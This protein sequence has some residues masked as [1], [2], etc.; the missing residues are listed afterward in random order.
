MLVGTADGSEGLKVSGT[1]FGAFVLTREFVGR[2]DG[3][4][5]GERL[6]VGLFKGTTDGLFD[7]SVDEVGPGVGTKS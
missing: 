1:K 5:V 4:G 2:K 6:N 7:V 3:V